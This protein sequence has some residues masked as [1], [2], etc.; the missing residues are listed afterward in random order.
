MNKARKTIITLSLVLVSILVLI[1]LTACDM[2]SILGGAPTGGKEEGKTAKIEFAEA[3]GN[4][5]SKNVKKSD[6]TI[7]LRGTLF[8]QQSKQAS[9]LKPEYDVGSTIT[10]QRIQNQ[11][12]VYASASIQ[13]S[14][15]DSAISGLLDIAARASSSDDNKASF[16]KKGESGIAFQ[17]SLD[18]TLVVLNH[19]FINGLKLNAELGYDNGTY[20]LKA[21][22]DDR[23]SKEDDKEDVWFVADKETLKDW[24]NEKAKMDVNDNMMNNFLM[25]TVFSGLKKT[26]NVFAKDNANNYVKNGKA[27]Y[28]ILLNSDFISQTISN[29]LLDLVGVED[30]TAVKGVYESYFSNIQDWISL[31]MENVCA[32]T[33]GDLLQDVKTG[34]VTKIN[35]NSSKV[36]ELL[37][38]LKN[39][40]FITEDAY[41]NVGYVIRM[42]QTFFCGTDEQTDRIGLK[43]SIELNEEFSYN[44]S[45]CDLSSD[46]YSDYFIG[47]DE[48]VEGRL[49]LSNVLLGLVEDIDAYI[50]S[51][52]LNLGEKYQDKIDEIKD[53]INEKV[54]EA[55]ADGSELSIPQIL[56]II[57]DI[58]REYR[59][60]DEME[61]TG[62]GD[63]E[64]NNS[65]TD[66]IKDIAGNLVDQLLDGVGGN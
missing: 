26:S 20:N 45:E 41:F 13:P 14:D 48:E 19:Y 4:Y 56:R 23:E 16:E 2:S 28:D 5:D 47:I 11:N 8:V 57:Q 65:T 7:K 27:Q 64:L 60:E 43:L 30:K 12:K 36:I 6:I 34:V 1:G 18:N 46:K 66:K 38:T 35:V 40:G 10:I 51:Y 55:T 37:Q 29:T 17:N 25:K 52:L 54:T 53:K 59:Q 31:E 33:N 50:T 32:N 63:E 15:T 22:Y 24:L 9:G 21:H 62:E 3:A 49:K 39:D 42:L 44:P 61:P 58:L